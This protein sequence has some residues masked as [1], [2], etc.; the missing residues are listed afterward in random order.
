MA[1][2]SRTAIATSLN[3]LPIF[4]TPL[5]DNM[6]SKQHLLILRILFGI[7]LFWTTMP[8]AQAKEIKVRS[9]TPICAAEQIDNKDNLNPS[10]QTVQTTQKP[11]KSNQD[12]D[13]PEQDEDPCKTPETS[14]AAEMSDETV[15][16]P[17]TPEVP[18]NEDSDRPSNPIDPSGD[19][20]SIPDESNSSQPSISNQDS[21]NLN[22]SIEFGGA[23]SGSDESFPTPEYSSPSEPEESS[24]PPLAPP[25]TSDSFD[26]PTPLLPSPSE[27][28]RQQI[29]KSKSHKKKHH[30]TKKLHKHNHDLNREQRKRSHQK[31]ETP[32]TQKAHRNHKPRKHQVQTHPMKGRRMELYPIHQ[33]NLS[34]PIRRTRLRQGGFYPTSPKRLP[35]VLRSRT[36]FHPRFRQ[37]ITPHRNF[38]PSVPRLHRVHRRH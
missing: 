22:F 23:S 35:N 27:P 1:P 10:A 19:D 29:Q 12:E 31:L 37:Q 8:K 18:T 17:E 3:I 5:E 21:H 24:P 13:T 2:R 14:E 7:T 11:Q 20:P 33:H 4:I 32:W 36:P 15:G 9:T 26:Q 34:K 25:A 28:Q 30:K 16:E 6:L 38:R